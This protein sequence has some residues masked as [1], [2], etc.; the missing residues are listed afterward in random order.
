M[1]R[2]RA[3]RARIELEGDV[4]RVGLADGRWRNLTLDGARFAA[5]DAACAQRFVRHLKLYLV[6]GRADLITPPDEGA[7]APRAAQLPGVPEDAFVVET[8]TWESVVDWMRSG[9]RLGGWTIAELARLCCIASAQFAITVGEWAARVAL[10][11]AWEQGGPMRSGCD[12]RWSLR[13]LEEAAAHSPRA[14]DA[15]VAALASVLGDGRRP[16]GPRTVRR[17][18]RSQGSHSA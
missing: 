16:S 11:A 14:A 12:P 18:V 8:S 6:D 7:I 1:P 13:P 3:P 5:R 10:D 4:L 9:G 15:L 2:A 17:P